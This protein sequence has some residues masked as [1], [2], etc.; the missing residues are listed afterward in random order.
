MNT[1]FLKFKE[2]G[3]VISLS[4]FIYTLLHIQSNLCVSFVMKLVANSIDSIFQGY[5][6]F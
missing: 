4:Q 2:L 3:E 6:L 5:H 1:F